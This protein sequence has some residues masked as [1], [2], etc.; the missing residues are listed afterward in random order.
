MLP[1]ASFGLGLL[2]G[3]S[4]LS[5]FLGGASIFSKG[6]VKPIVDGVSQFRRRGPEARTPIKLGRPFGIEGV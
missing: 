5:T 6:D 2:M 1:A 4:G 3:G